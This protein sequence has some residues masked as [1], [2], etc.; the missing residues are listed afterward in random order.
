MPTITCRHQ[1]KIEEKGKGIQLGTCRFCGQVREYNNEQ[2][3]YY[4]KI[5]KLG[6]LDGAVVLPGPKDEVAVTT[7]E[8]A[9]LEAA[10]KQGPSPKSL[11]AV[12]QEPPPA[13]AE[14]AE[15]IPENI[16]EPATE[17]P[18][19][20]VRGIRKWKRRCS[21]CQ[22]SY[23]HDDILW[24]SSKRCP[25]RCP[26]RLRPVYRPKME[27]AKKG[28]RSVPKKQLRALGLTDKNGIAEARLVPADLATAE[29]LCAGC[30]V[31]QMF[32][33]YQM[34]VRDL[35]GKWR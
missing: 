1:E 34:A 25:Q 21:D 20:K 29:E 26:P 6:H 5:V 22:L 13:S 9:E 16:P 17:T 32:R 8:K 33:G 4:Q 31:L 3:P 24:C 10:K 18:P 2:A 28:L 7:Q 15:N 27:P 19:P 12:P 35:S 23:L 14:P 30:P 11:P